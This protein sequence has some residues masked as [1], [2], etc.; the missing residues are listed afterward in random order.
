MT[1]ILGLPHT[2]HPAVVVPPA[3]PAFCTSGPSPGQYP[4]PETLATIQAH[5][6]DATELLTLSGNTYSY[7]N[8]GAVEFLY[9]A[10]F[11]DLID[12]TSGKTALEFGITPPVLSGGLVAEDI[13]MVVSLFT[14]PSLYGL[15]VVFDCYADGTFFRSVR[16]G[17]IT[18]FSDTTPPPSRVTFAVDADTGVG[19]ILLDGVSVA[20]SAP[21][22]FPKEAAVVYV[23]AGEAQ[24][25]AAPNTGKT[26]SIQVITKIA[27]MLHAPAGYTDICGN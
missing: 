8:T 10:N 15:Q 24:T 21:G 16:I 26:F 14:G 25:I 7:T 23:A 18:L 11:T 4:L 1:A 13:L 2:D 20:A 27:D 22:A 17:G 5:F 19:E 3:P 6:P 9:A 12:F